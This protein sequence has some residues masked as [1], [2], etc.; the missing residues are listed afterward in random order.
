MPARMRISVVLPAPLGPSSPNMPVGTSQVE[1]VEGGHAAA[2]GL[3]QARRSRSA[4]Q[5]PRVRV[6]VAIGLDGRAARAAASAAAREIQ[7]HGDGQPA[8]A[9]VGSGA[10]SSAWRRATGRPGCPSPSM[11][12]KSS[13]ASRR[14]AADRVDEGVG[15]GRHHGP[16]GTRLPPEP[17]DDEDHAEQRCRHE[18]GHRP[19]RS[20]ATN[21]R[22][23]H[24][25]RT[26]AASAQPSA[27][28]AP[29]VTA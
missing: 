14:V 9:G 17:V 12:W 24:D 23:G 1:A 19:A 22:P 25:D 27:A 29:R 4:C 5:V 11:T 13:S 3:R 18:Q 28:G 16:A 2:V 6:G 7:Q 10:G 15:E 20:A 21:S 8:V 26:R